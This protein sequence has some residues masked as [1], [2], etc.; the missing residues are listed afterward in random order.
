M[1]KSQGGV[2]K[3]SFHHVYFQV[4]FKC[5]I[6]IRNPENKDKERKRKKMKMKKKSALG[7]LTEKKQFSFVQSHLSILALIFWTT[8]VILEN[9]FLCISLPEEQFLF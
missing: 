8:G 4:N 1:A 9:D 6:Q 5:R 3:A 7:I 2:G